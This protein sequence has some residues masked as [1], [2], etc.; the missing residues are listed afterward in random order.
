MPTYPSLVTPKHVLVLNS[1]SS[2]LKFALIE[3]VSG[4]RRLRGQVDRVGTEAPELVYELRAGGEARSGHSTLNGSTHE[5]ALEG[6]FELLQR[7]VAGVP[8][9]AVGHRVVH[10]GER[11]REPV[12]VDD[13][14]VR[15]I[16]SVSHLAPL[17]NPHC[18]T[19][20]RAARSARPDLS[21]VAVFDTAFHQTM[22]EHAFRYAIPEAWYREHG[23]RRYGFHGTSHQFV[24][25]AAARSLGGSVSEL[26]LLSAHLGNGSSV[27]A[28]DRGRSVENTMGLTP[29][30]GL[31]MGTRSGDIDPGAVLFMAGRLEGGVEAVEHALNRESGLRG[32]SGFSNDVRELLAAEAA[33]NERAR[34]ALEVYCYRLAAAIAQLSVALPRLDALVFTGGIGENAVLVRSRTVE[35]LRPLGFELDPAA[36]AGPR[37]GTLRIDAGRGPKI[38]VIPTDEEWMIA[39]TVAAL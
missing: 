7:E 1:G 39:K 27:T 29:L 17:H 6:L 9:S 2:S 5:A 20:I 37:E 25:E 28:V 13:D 16:E 34:L 19:G 30:S 32:L 31:V 10:G 22:P 21:H 35:R 11:F 23:V 36:N 4:A 8:L 24:T 12:V 18:L 33:G 26:C 15:A 38:L 14:V 3:P